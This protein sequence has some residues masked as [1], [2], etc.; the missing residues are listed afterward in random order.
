[1][2][3]TLLLTV[4]L[5]TAADFDALWD[6]Y[7]AAG[8]PA[9][10]EF[11][12]RELQRAGWPN[13]FELTVQRLR[14]RRYPDDE[15]RGVLRE[16]RI[17][18]R[19]LRYPYIALVPETYDPDRAYPLQVVLHGSTRRAPWRDGEDHWPSIDPFRN[20]EIITVFPAAWD[21]A[22]WWSDRQIE[23]LT[24]LLDELR[25]R[26]HIDSNR[27][28][29]TGLSDG[30]TGTFYQAMRAPTPWAAFIPLIG[31]PWVL[32]NEEEG[33]DGDIFAANLRGRALMVVNGE[34]DHLYPAASL[35]SYLDLFE[36][37]GATVQF[38]VKPGGH[39]VRWW[40]KETSN[41]RAFR[42]AHPRDPFPD[43]LVWET[44]DPDRNG[45][46]NWI[47]IQAI[48]VEPSLG[49]DPLNTVL[50][51]ELD[52][53]TRA[54]AFPRRARSGRI[55][56]HRKGNRIDVEMQN[57]ER[58]LLLLGV[59]GLDHSQPV[60]VAQHGIVAVHRVQ[61][62]VATL[63]HWAI[64]DGDPELLIWAEIQIHKQP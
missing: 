9:G 56:V 31:H 34:D 1:M 17:D 60:Q 53:P 23:N 24:A 25:A 41:F 47:V 33:V 28:T 49:P 43:E 36:R 57:V 19:G 39:N 5:T 18:L 55:T 63:M 38:K 59:G 42:N 37:A 26:Y 48:G 8:D 50:F 46:A 32:G 51:P 62:S 11:A 14:D 6:R 61:P 10:R 3:L 52:P 21:Q 30:G 13:D 58:A 27:C 2:I 64:R 45:R 12:W 4:S 16:S 29:L 20:E 40:P 15:P 54:D 44:T 22:M 7:H 35:S